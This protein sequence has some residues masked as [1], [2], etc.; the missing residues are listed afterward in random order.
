MYL[1]MSMFLSM[2]VSKPVLRSLDL[3]SYFV[4]C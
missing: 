1:S 4:V 2:S 3:R